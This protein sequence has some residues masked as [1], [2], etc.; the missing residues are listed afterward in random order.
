MQPPPA[1]PHVK[2]EPEQQGQ[3]QREEHEPAAAAGDDVV[4][5]AVSTAA[6]RDRA[7]RASAIVLLDDGTH[8]QAVAYRLSAEER[9]R[10]QDDA[11]LKELRDVLSSDRTLFGEKMHTARDLFQQMDRDG[12]GMI[13]ADEFRVAFQRLGLGI[14]PAQLEHL[15]GL[16]DRDGNG[17]VDYRELLDALDGAVQMH[18]SPEKAMMSEHEQRIATAQ[19]RRRQALEQLTKGR[20]QLKNALGKS[21]VLE[22]D[23]STQ[24]SPAQSQRPDRERD[25]DE[26]EN[27]ARRLNELLEAQAQAARQLEELQASVHQAEAEAANAKRSA[28]EWRESVAEAEEVAKSLGE[29][30]QSRSDRIAELEREDAARL[31]QQ[32]MDATDVAYRSPQKSGTDSAA[33]AVQ[34]NPPKSSVPSKHASVQAFSSELPSFKKAVDDERARYDDACAA[35]KRKLAAEQSK[36]SKLRMA[37]ERGQ[38][39]AEREVE[40]LGQS[41][42]KL[43]DELGE[44]KG[45]HGELR[46]WVL[47]LFELQQTEATRAM[48]LLQLECERRLA[49]ANEATAAATS[50]AVAAKADSEKQGGLDELHSIVS[51]LEVS[52]EVEIAALKAHFDAEQNSLTGALEVAAADLA[53]EKGKAVGLAAKVEAAEA[54]AVE[55]ET[56]AM[57]ALQ[58][59][60]D[61]ERMVSEAKQAEQA[62]RDAETAAKAS[63]EEA[64]AAQRLSEVEAE[65]ESKVASAAT[66][67]GKVMLSQVHELAGEIGSFL[68]KQKRF[69]EQREAANRAARAAGGGV[70]S[71]ATTEAVRAEMDKVNATLKAMHA[72]Q[73]TSQQA[74]VA[75]ESSARAEAE[76]RVQQE[77]AAAASELQEIRAAA[78]EA[79]RELEQTKEKATV[80]ETEMA[81]VE[82]DLERK[83]VRISPPIC[84]LALTTRKVSMCG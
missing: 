28:Q 41:C 7:A 77:I 24:S 39:L 23:D 47:E 64:S 44:I 16:M 67:E 36:D 13:E 76:A 72:A 57:D 42:G 50:A 5:T 78:V 83:T 25:H 8:T 17:A 80:A 75:A 66:A 20:E 84:A 12:S 59:A 11:I 27:A 58:L 54:R 81:R 9:V 63:V 51:E 71:G 48:L 38:T 4:V 45:V 18:S 31:R 61:A 2:V 14:T 82:S 52:K 40:R 56:A 68:E 43:A 35:L 46:G 29:E 53:A 79:S 37:A 3:Q 34:A 26:E 69:E 74:A 1:P 21:P 10:A 65:V 30:I 6:E 15:M 73:A 70:E 32:A 33:A 22:T 49:A 62:A 19:E 60:A 55:A